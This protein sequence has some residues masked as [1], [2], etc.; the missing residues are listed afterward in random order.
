M[1]NKKV[2][3]EAKTD[4]TLFRRGMCP[5]WGFPLVKRGR[6][7]LILQKEGAGSSTLTW[8]LRGKKRKSNTQEG[9]LKK[10]KKRGTL[11]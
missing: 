7:T 5:R 9:K 3:L 6:E 8:G 2:L 4:G 1:G 11:K 10:G